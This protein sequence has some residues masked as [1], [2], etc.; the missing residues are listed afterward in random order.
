MPATFFIGITPPPEFAA[1]VQ[2]W[3]A[4]LEH[5]VTAPHVTL[6]F[7]AELPERRWVEAASSVAARHS[8]VP[9]RLGG[10]DSFGSRV[11][12]LKVDAPGLHAV[13]TDLVEALNEPPGEFALEKYHPHLTLALAWRPMNTRW[14]PAVSSARHEFAGQ[15]TRPLE[16]VA[17]EL[18]LFGK[19]A[20]GQPYT[21]RARFALHPP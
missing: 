5:L 13:H 14:Q 6:L 10:P 11:I 8:P 2:R 15:D 7:P 19:A 16:F 4:G 1:R 20:P 18:V 3:Q 17:R 9:V 12:F 21:E